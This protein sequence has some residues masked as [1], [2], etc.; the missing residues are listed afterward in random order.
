MH[1]KLIELFVEA[2]EYTGKPV[3]Y[4][5]WRFYAMQ[6]LGVISGSVLANLL[7][8]IYDPTCF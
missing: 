7:I 2:A 1:Q 6:G 4:V 5:M 8:Y 3:E